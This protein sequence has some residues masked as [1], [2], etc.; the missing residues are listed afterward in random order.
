M[1]IN[2]LTNYEKTLDKEDQQKQL[3]EMTKVLKLLKEK[4]V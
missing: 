4:K 1:V 2:A 3:H